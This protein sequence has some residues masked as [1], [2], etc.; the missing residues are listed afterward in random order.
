MAAGFAVNVLLTRLLTPAEVGA[1]FL[2]YSLVAAASA[3]AMLGLNFSI[4]RLVAESLS[5]DQPGRAK[6]AILLTFAIVF[7]AIF[8]LDAALI[9]IPST[10][11]AGHIFVEGGRP[12]VWLTAAWIAV[13]T[14]QLISAEVFRGM[15]DIRSASVFGGLVIAV[16]G[17]LFFLVCLVV[18]VHLTLPYAVAL[19]VVAGAANFVFAGWLIRGKVK[20]LNA[21]PRFHFREMLL[22][23]APLWIANLTLL[24]LTQADVWILSTARSHDAVA[25]YGAAVRMTTFMTVPLLVINSTLLP[26]I[27]ELYARGDRKA[28]ERTLRGTAALGVI[29]AA[30]VLAFFCIF[31]S[32]LMGVAFGSFYS[33]GFYVLLIL[34]VG[35]L[36]NIAGG[37]CAYVLMMTGHQREMMWITLIAGIGT[38]VLGFALVSS[39]G[40]LGV[41]TGSALGLMFQTIAMWLCTRLRL[42]IWT[43]CSMA[44]L[45]RLLLTFKRT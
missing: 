14:L 43:H 42:G 3:V 8:L 16:L 34:S 22:I 19:S 1:Y 15:H 25:V 28:L 18:G 38:V 32:G 29:P 26:V 10:W 27:S 11:L 21:I 2:I 31:G 30:L 41:A 39:Y 24:V 45:W 36:V 33:G 6:G 4:V 23:S 20:T 44:N 13:F 9:T 5:L 37:S 17:A 35:Q 7:S 40:A 12:L